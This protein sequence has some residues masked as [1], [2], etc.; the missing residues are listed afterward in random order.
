MKMNKAS[1]E[2]IVD[3][4]SLLCHLSGLAAPSGE[5]TDYKNTPPVRFFH[6]S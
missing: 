4:A 6:A 2:L 5:S 3:L 1:S